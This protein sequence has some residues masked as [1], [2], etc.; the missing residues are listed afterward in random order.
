MEFSDPRFDFLSDYVLKSMKLKNDKWAKLQGNEEYR[1]QIINFFEKPD[2]H[3]LVIMQNSAGQLQPLYD[4]PLALKTKAVYIAKKEKAVNI[5]KDNVKTALAFGDLS[6]A[7][8]EQLF[9][10]VEEVCCVFLVE[11][12]VVTGTRINFHICL[13]VLSTTLLI[14]YLP[15]FGS[16]S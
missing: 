4:F 15:K 11:F 9:A 6:Y 14:L 13:F 5:G 3:L 16:L 1:Q 7:P 12:I 8:P 2:L 10:L